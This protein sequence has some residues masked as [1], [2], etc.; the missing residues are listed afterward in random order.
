MFIDA[1]FTG[2]LKVNVISPL[3]MSNVYC[4]RFGLST[5]RM[6]LSTTFEIMLTKLLPLVSVIAVGLRFT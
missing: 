6:K 5:S 1:A 4:S 2:S 3:F